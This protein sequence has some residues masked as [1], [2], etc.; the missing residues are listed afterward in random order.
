VCRARTVWYSSVYRGAEFQH[1][2]LG[3]ELTSAQ[4]L[5]AEMEEGSMP[6]YVDSSR[7]DISSDVREG[8]YK[9]DIR[10]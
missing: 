2:L 4:D 8:L 6:H 1:R 10:T 3:V 7:G 5:V 9:G